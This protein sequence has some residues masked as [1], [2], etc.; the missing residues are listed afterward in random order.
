MIAGSFYLQH[1]LH[2]VNQYSHP[3]AAGEWIKIIYSSICYSLCQSLSLHMVYDQLQDG[4]CVEHTGY[5]Y[6]L[7][8]RLSLTSDAFTGCIKPGLLVAILNG[9]SSAFY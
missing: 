8:C 2:A 9:S 7:V 1:P 5:E 3:E 4:V 6:L